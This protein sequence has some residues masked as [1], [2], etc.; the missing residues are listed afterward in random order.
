MI[1]GSIYSS[2][3]DLLKLKV[4]LIL[5][6][7]GVKHPNIQEDAYNIMGIYV[8]SYYYYDNKLGVFSYIP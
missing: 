1:Y 6:K 8:S 3:R 4:A 7:I 2:R 5:H